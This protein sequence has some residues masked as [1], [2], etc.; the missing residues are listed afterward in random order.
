MPL[1][2]LLCTATPSESHYFDDGYSVIHFPSY[3]AHTFFGPCS[4][5]RAPATH[6]GCEA[7]G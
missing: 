7:L 2:D 5:P 3:D 6:E 4:S 1:G